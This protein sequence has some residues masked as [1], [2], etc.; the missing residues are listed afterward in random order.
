MSTGKGIALVTGAAQG[1]GQAIAL[2]LANDGFDVA[3]NDVPSK[4][5]QLDAVA[6][7]VN[8]TGHN[9]LVVC[10]DV[11]IEED[12][13][14]MIKAAVEVLGGL[15][16]MVANAGISGS[17]SPL[18]DT[19]KLGDKLFAI[20]AR[21]VY[22]CYKHA[23]KQMIAQGRGGRII[24]ASS[25]A[26]KRAFPL[27]AIYCA[28]KFAVRGLTQSAASELGKYG[29]TVNSYAPGIIDT[30]ML[31]ALDGQGDKDAIAAAVAAT[32]TSYMGKPEDIAGIVSYLA[33]KEAHF[34]TGQSFSVDGGMILS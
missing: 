14:A 26:G 28:S 10:A 29:I 5:S 9:A 6:Q 7:M 32:P 25:A 11:S 18:V 30:P 33:S 1:I 22:L 8:A 19:L 15:D 21:G 23:A 34:I 27:N 13:V 4:K 16:V 20:N 3:L 17:P 24:G 2:Q 31:Q 12:V